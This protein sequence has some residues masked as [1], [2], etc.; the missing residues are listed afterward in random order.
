MRAQKTA[1]DR[2]WIKNNQWRSLNKKI[3]I[4]WVYDRVLG[5]QKFKHNQTDF[6]EFTH[7]A[8]EEFI[9]FVPGITSS[10]ELTVQLYCT[11]RQTVSDF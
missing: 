8:T 7:H 4:Q 6:S 9:T 5:P 3:L 1:N 11:E 10:S 2:A